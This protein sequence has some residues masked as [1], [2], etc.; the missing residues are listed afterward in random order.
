MRIGLVVAVMV[1]CVVLPT[2]GRAD[3]DAGAAPLSDAEACRR[4]RP[5]RVEAVQ[6]RTKQWLKRIA[7]MRAACTV[8]WTKSG[9]FTAHGNRIAPEIVADVKCP[10]GPPQGETK[11]SVWNVLSLFL[12]GEP[13]TDERMTTG[14]QFVDDFNV[15]CVSQDA[16]SGLVLQPLVSDLPALRRVV[17]WK[18]PPKK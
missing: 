5:P 6:L 17:A 3:E 7:D 18:P 15:R 14:E 4:S 2:L 1:G 10:K 11:E 13:P 12:E 9:A 16:E 8:G